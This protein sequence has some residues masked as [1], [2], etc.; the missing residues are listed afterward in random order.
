[1]SLAVATASS[2]A[3]VLSLTFPRLLTGL[4]AE[5]T[6]ALYSAL[7]V[8]AFTLIFL[9]V[10][11]T[12]LRTL[13]EL[14][15]VFSFRTRDFVKYQVTEFLPWFIKRYILRQQTAELQPLIHQGDYRALEH[16]EDENI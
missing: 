1:M 7:N 16:E 11:E 3:T 10:P 8:L 14:D 5:G 2:W 9:F 12:K 13:E 4:R 15:Q 6:F